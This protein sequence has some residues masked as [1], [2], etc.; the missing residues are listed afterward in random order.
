MDPS[1]TY[2]IREIY[3]SE[4][5]TSN[6]LYELERA[7]STKYKYIIIEPKRLAEETGRWI[8]MGNII[9]RTSVLS[10]LGAIGLA[11][12]A[13]KRLWM[14]YSLCGVSIVVSGIYAVSWNSDHCSKYQLE[15]DFSKFNETVAKTATRILVYKDNRLLNIVQRSVAASA[16]LVICGFQVYRHLK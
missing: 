12:I 13:P 4:Q 15:R 3:E 8:T 14:S 7:L 16:F 9:H 1:S 6:F 11:V 5:S 2:V 10:G